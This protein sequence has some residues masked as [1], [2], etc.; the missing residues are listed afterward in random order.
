MTLFTILA[1]A[2]AL[3][4]TLALLAPLLLRTAVRRTRA[5][6]DAAL[7]RDQLAEVERDLE[8]GVIT[9]AEADG[10]RTEVSRRLI[11]AATE[12][13]RDDTPGPA[14]QG[15]TG[16]V[17]G[18]ALIGL[19]AL[20][21]LL[22]MGIGAPGMPDQPLAA[23]ERLGPG[24]GFLAQ[25]EAEE[26]FAE[27]VPP[28]LALAPEE[29][30]L[31]ARLEERVETA[32]DDAQALQ[33]YAGLLMRQRRFGEAWP[34]WQRLGARAE[35]APAAEYLARQAEAMILAA[36]G[37]VSAEAEQ[38]IADALDRAPRL[39][40]AR[41]YAGLAM[42]QRGAAAAALKIWEDLRRD[43]PDA[44]FAPMLDRMI[45]QAR[46]EVGADTA[47]PGPSADDMAAAAAMDPAERQS[48][49]E[50]MVAGLQDRLATEGGDANAWFRLMNAQVVLGRMDA[51]RE[52]YARAQEALP[53]D[54]A[55][56]LRE[57]ALLLGVI[58]E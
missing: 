7:F 17:A 43:A 42:A 44:P 49:I 26:R 9:E 16:M 34:I 50:S 30:G 38:A 4:A 22:Y 41:Y 53:S 14:P 55:G 11:A 6:Q 37:Y 33:F 32:P 20:A 47:A 35:G 23:R 28:P 1:G 58:A 29:A 27:Q 18:I 2:L 24:A 48:M 13:E 52:T 8:R 39:D 12:A 46:A 54:G 3:L 19:P 57:Q 10:A 56:F 21:A 36:G 51:A 25:T 5:E 15:G 31:F 40:I 45:A